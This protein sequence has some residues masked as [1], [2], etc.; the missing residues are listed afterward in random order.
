M[1]ELLKTNISQTEAQADITNSK[2]LM[3]HRTKSSRSGNQECRSAP[4]AMQPKM[5]PDLSIKMQKSERESIQKIGRDNL[6]MT[7]EL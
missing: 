4:S 3:E 6:R 1:E 5:I 2:S 7:A